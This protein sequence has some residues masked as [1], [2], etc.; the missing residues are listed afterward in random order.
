MKSLTAVVGILTGCIGMVPAAHAREVVE[1]LAPAQQGW[2]IQEGRYTGQVEGDRVRLTA[3]LTVKVFGEGIQEV[4]LEFPGATITNVQIRG[5]SAELAVSGDQYRLLF[6][7]KGT[8]RVLVEMSVPLS[9]QPEEGFSLQI[10]QALFS[11][12]SLTV[13]RPD[14]ELAPGQVLT[15]QKRPG[16]GS[17]TLEASYGLGREMSLY[18]KNKPSVEKVD[19]VY[20]GEV[21]TTVFLREEGIRTVT[22]LNVQVHQGKVRQLLLDIPAGQTVSAVRAAGLEDWKV[23]SGEAG[24]QLSLEFQEDLTLGTT[25]ITVEMEQPTIT[26]EEG[27]VKLQVPV[28]VG[29]KRFSGYLGLA[30]GT[31]LQVLGAEGEGLHRIDVR[32]LPSELV[33]AAGL[34]VLQAFRCQQAPYQITVSL[35]R[36]KELPVLAAV[37]E[38]AEISLLVTSAGE[39]MVRAIYQI[40]NNRKESLSVH[41]PL[42][43]TLWSV[44]VNQQPVKPVA[45]TGEEVLIPLSIGGGPEATFPVEVFYVQKGNTFAMLGRSGFIG[46][47]LDVPITVTSVD[48]FLPDELFPISFSGNLQRHLHVETGLEP[49]PVFSQMDGV[50]SSASLQRM[51]RGGLAMKESSPAEAEIQQWEKAQDRAVESG[52]LPFRIP[53]PRSGQL[54][55]FGRLLLTSEPVRLE[56]RYAKLPV[57]SFWLT[58]S[59]IGLAGLLAGLKRRSRRMR[60]PAAPSSVV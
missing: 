24:P 58:T 31:S 16:S 12:L 17:V 35:K 36:P 18:W 26:K 6:Q 15:V 41:L 49:R 33:R 27:Q 4:P 34:P 52:V 55:R 60:K 39:A 1:G 32:E 45:G 43:A 38:R 11:R 50:A 5:G 3:E 30:N 25:P 40:R 23:V 19:P 51:G 54:Y 46:P 21:Y 47:V 22:W 9:R 14:V 20:S 53:M 37:V 8:C 13:P 10:P 28:L 44:A 2:A 48:L 29:A 42:G 7:R 56:V 59:G 57:V